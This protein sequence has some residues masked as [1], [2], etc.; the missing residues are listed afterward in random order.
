MYTIAVCFVCTALIAVIGSALFAVTVTIVAVS[1]G[2][3]CASSAVRNPARAW[4]SAMA[5]QA[6]LLPSLPPQ[7]APLSRN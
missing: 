4:I 5:S 2:V 3:K 6:K 1:Y 7:R